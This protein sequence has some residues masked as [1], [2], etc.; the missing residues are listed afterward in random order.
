MLSCISICLYFLF[1]TKNLYSRVM[2]F[3]GLFSACSGGDVFASR[4]LH[5][6][7]LMGSCN[8]MPWNMHGTVISTLQFLSSGGRER[9]IIDGWS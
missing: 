1:S 7:N 2:K 8:Y 3:T 6:L 5:L 4:V 9:V